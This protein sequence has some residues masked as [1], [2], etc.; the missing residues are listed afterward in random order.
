MGAFVMYSRYLAAVALAV[1]LPFAGTSVHAASATVC[2]QSLEYDLTPPSADVGTKARLLVGVWV[3]EV[4]AKNP[5]NL[6]YTRCFGL[7][8]EHVTAGGIVLGQYAAGPSVKMMYSGTAFTVKP[9]TRSLNGKI[10]G[11]VMSFRDSIWTFEIQLPE[12]D[13]MQGRFSNQSGPGTIFFKKQ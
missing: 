13:R 9:V 10:D 12:S 7:V 1:G 2:G 4:F 8:I 3:G 11:D 5:Q 6:D